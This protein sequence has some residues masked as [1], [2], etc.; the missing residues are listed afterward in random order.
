MSAIGLNGHSNCPTALTNSR[1]SG[2]KRT[3]SSGA[4][5]VG[6]AQ[7]VEH[8]EIA[9]YG[10]LKAWALELGLDDAASLLETTLKEEEDTDHQLSE[11]A[12]KLINQ[13]A[14]AAE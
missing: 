1:L 6:A 5:L 14:E 2:R 10:T 3:W 13:K 11:L 4:A 9:R 8:Y 12:V 7:A